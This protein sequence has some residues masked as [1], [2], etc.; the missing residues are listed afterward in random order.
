[1][2]CS[3][4]GQLIQEVLELLLS[5]FFK[6]QFNG[7]NKKNTELGNQMVFAHQYSSSIF[8]PWEE[9]TGACL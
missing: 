6:I 5:P 9:R 1:M 8:N 7:T 3:T 2:E 4:L